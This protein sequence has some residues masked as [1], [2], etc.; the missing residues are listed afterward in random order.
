MN[1]YNEE[2]RDF[3]AS[4]GSNCRRALHIMEDVPVN[5]CD[6]FQDSRSAESIAVHEAN[7]VFCETTFCP[8]NQDRCNPSCVS[9]RS[10]Q[11]SNGGASGARC[12][13]PL[14]TEENLVKVIMKVL[15]GCQNM[16]LLT[17]A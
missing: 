3:D 4:Y 13:H 14:L 8:V 11:F 17:P 6:D 2:C 10:A 9:F 1:C 16:G 12:G 7:V 5:T 15:A